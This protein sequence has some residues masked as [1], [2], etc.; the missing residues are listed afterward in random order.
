MHAMKNLKI[1]NCLFVL[2]G[3]LLMFSSC[4]PNPEE[5]A[6]ETCDCLESIIG[7]KLFTEKDF[8][9]HKDSCSNLIKLKYNTDTDEKLRKELKL[10][11][12]QITGSFGKVDNA[13]NAQI[14]A[15][16]GKI[17][18]V[19][20]ETN[21][22]T[23]F[24][25][26]KL[27]YGI[28]DSIGGLI[29]RWYGVG[30][31]YEVIQKALK[32]NVVEVA[33]N[34]FKTKYDMQPKGFVHTY[35][36]INNKLSERD[37]QGQWNFSIEK[38]DRYLFS[39]YLPPDF[40]HEYNDEITIGYTAVN[41]NKGI[42]IMKDMEGD[43]SGYDLPNFYI[44]S[45]SDDLS[46]SAGSKDWN[47]YCVNISNPELLNDFVDSEILLVGTYDGIGAEENFQWGF[48]TSYYLQFSN[49]E[50][51]ATSKD[52]GFITKSLDP[53][54][55][56]IKYLKNNKSL[57]GNNANSR[58]GIDENENLSQN[59]KSDCMEFLEDYEKFMEEYIVFIK[60][61][62][63]NPTDATLISDYTKMLQ[64]ASEWTEVDN[65]CA[66]DPAFIGKYTEIQMKIANAASEMYK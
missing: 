62:L 19:Y 27:L 25:S 20:N 23:V 8:D 30:L 36:V 40:Q 24:I 2:I 59:S 48:E 46:Y 63:K 10:Y 35:Y 32:S 42:K 6:N 50:I 57:D 26:D 51:I 4:G 53:I 65:E 13:Y 5:I 29:N 3:A 47:V 34:N 7:G 43:K 41:T 56:Y 44:A 60:K 31:E 37:H 16:S 9:Y 61:Y 22:S 14:E 17:A 55:E 66:N 38:G 11:E 52:M 28:T 12:K 45:Y 15:V 1:K 39:L 21:S 49:C 58:N 33:K 64:Q 18:T 54:D